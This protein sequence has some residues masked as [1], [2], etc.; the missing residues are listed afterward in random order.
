M[1]LGAGLIVGG[2]NKSGGLQPSPSPLP[3]PPLRDSTLTNV[4]YGANDQQIM[5]VYLPAGRSQQTRLIVI[6]HGGGWRAGDKS[7]FDNYVTEFKNRLPG[8]AIANL[9]YR[10]VDNPNNLF[11]TQENDIKSAIG[12]LKE[13]ATSYTISSDMI[14]LGISAGAHLALLQAYKHPDIVRPKGIVSFY[15]P[16]NLAD[17][18]LVLPSVL[19]NI[20]GFTPQQNPT[21][22]Q[23]SSPIHYVSASSAPTLLLHGDADNVVPLAHA[24]ALQQKLDELNVTNS[25]VVYPGQGHDGWNGESLTDSFNKIQ[26]FILS[27]EKTE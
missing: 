16:P 21:I 18:Y 15:G 12:F 8:Y 10:L 23:E 11:P 9:N 14:L 3:K 27:L 17:L 24:N 25:L 19:R 13:K 20:T 1:M 7:D 5:D 2:C 22:Y 26:S 6:I 4:H